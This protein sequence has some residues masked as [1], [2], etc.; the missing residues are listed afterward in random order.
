MRFTEQTLKTIV[1]LSDTHGNRQPFETLDRVLAECDYIFHLGD[2][3]A[4]GNILKNRYPKNTYVLNG[5]C[6]MFEIGE[7]EVCVQVEGVKIFACHGD[8]YG[9]KTRTD[10]LT[11]RAEELGCKLALFGH[12]HEAAELCEGGVTLVNPGALTRYGRQSYAYIVI[13]GDKIVS[14]IVEL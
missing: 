10:L 7:R 1:V 5:N 6:D 8:R 3:S 14:K 13:N 2:T 12:T 11:Y 9:V 4:D